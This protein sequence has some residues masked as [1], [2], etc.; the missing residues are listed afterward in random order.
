MLELFLAVTTAE[1]ALE[2][3]TGGTGQGAGAGI[4]GGAEGA[5]ETCYE[6]EYNVFMLCCTLN[7]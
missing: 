5:G 6:K 3:E 7:N 2:T 4:E 1:V